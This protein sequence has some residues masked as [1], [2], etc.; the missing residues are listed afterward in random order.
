V[1]RW[2]GRAVLAG[3]AALLLY[4]IVFVTRSGRGLRPLGEGDPAPE[5][6][7]VPLLGGAPVASSTLRGEVVLVDFWATWC[8]PCRQSMPALERLYRA[9]HASGFRVLSVNIESA[10]MAKRA[11]AF[12]ARMNLTF[13]LFRDREGSAQDAFKVTAIPHLILV[14]R[15]GSVRLVHVGGVGGD[16][17][18]ELS[19]AIRTL[20]AEP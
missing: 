15:K 5:F 1:S 14:D 17:E 7:V 6:E 3:L 11:E 9:H 8:Q 2:V 18:E 10:R 20:Q 4:N 12:A 13:P 16:D 19:A